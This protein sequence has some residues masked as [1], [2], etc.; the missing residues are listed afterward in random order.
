MASLD[1][2]LPF[3][4]PQALAAGISPTVLQGPRFTAVFRGVHVGSGVPLAREIR[5]RAALLTHP[6]G[7]YVSHHTAAELLGLPVPHSPLVHVSVFER[8]DRR[9]RDGIRSH[10]AR[11]QSLMTLR[12]IPICTPV[13]LFLDM[14]AHLD[15]VDLVVLG[16]AIVRRKLATVSELVAAADRWQERHGAAARRAARHVRAKVD[17]A[18][19]SRLRMLLVLAG[20]P[21]PEVN[22]ELR[23]DSG[24]VLAALDLSYPEVKLAIEYDGQ[25]HRADLGQ[26][27]SDIDRGEWLTRD[28][29]RILPVISTGIYRRP[30][31]TIE[32][33]HNA[34]VQLRYPGLP[35]RLSEDWR[36][37][38]PVRR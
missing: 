7:A 31:Q 9:R 4:R 28:G 1:T 35:R 38:F 10:L 34:L 3:T 21:E 26:W 27:N 6:V 33:V 32:R 20:L 15:L 37:Y 17:S 14:A 18:M 36:A 16:D 8:R 23:N 19:E 24:I 25:Q 13:G 11:R 5:A 2:H 12:G 29:W 22:R 30:D